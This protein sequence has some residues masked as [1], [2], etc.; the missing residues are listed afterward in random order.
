LRS[1]GSKRCET[2][3]Q[4]VRKG[5]PLLV[6]GRL[7]LDRWEKNGQKNSKIVCIVDSFEFIPRRDRDSEQE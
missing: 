5:D 2:I 4:Y 1:V 6:E 7:R 3:A